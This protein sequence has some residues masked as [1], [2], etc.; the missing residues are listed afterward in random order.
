MSVSNTVDDLIENQSEI[1]ESQQLINSSDELDPTNDNESL[2]MESNEQVP[3]LNESVEI[4]Y[5][6]S[7][8]NN[9]DVLS[10]PFAENTNS[11]DILT[12]NTNSNDILTE[13]T[14]SNHYSIESTNPN[15]SIIENS[16]M[17]NVILTPEGT[18]NQTEPAKDTITDETQINNKA[19]NVCKGDSN[20]HNERNKPMNIFQ[21]KV[22][23]PIALPTILPIVSLDYQSQQKNKESPNNVISDSQLDD[24]MKK[25]IQKIDDSKEAIESN[26]SKLETSLTSSNIASESSDKTNSK[27]N[28]HAENIPANTLDEEIIKVSSQEV[29]NFTRIIE[30]P[31]EKDNSENL[32]SELI[33]QEAD[34]VIPVIVPSEQKQKRKK[35]KTKNS[36]KEL[37][38]DQ[39]SVPPADIESGSMVDNYKLDITRK[40]RKIKES[41]KELSSNLEETPLAN[42]DNKVTPNPNQPIGL[43]NSTDPPKSFSQIEKE[44]ISV[45]YN[46]QPPSSSKKKKSALKNLTKGTISNMNPQLSNNLQVTTSYTSDSTDNL[47]KYKKILPITSQAV[48]PN[49]YPVAHESFQSR[50][51]P[52]LSHDHPP[53]TSQL[54]PPEIKPLSV[55]FVQQNESSHRLSTD[56]LSGYNQFVQGSRSNV[57]HESSSK[58][59]NPNTIDFYERI[60]AKQVENSNMSSNTSNNNTN[61]FTPLP[62]P[63]A[64]ST[65]MDS[66][67]ELLI[68]RA[69]NYPFRRTPNT[70]QSRTQGVDEEEVQYRGQFD[71]KV[72]PNKVESLVDHRM[73]KPYYLPGNQSA[74][75]PFQVGALSRNK[76][77]NSQHVPQTNHDS[78]QRTRS[79]LESSAQLPPQPDSKTI[80]RFPSIAPF[81]E[82]PAPA[83][84]PERSSANALQQSNVSGTLTSRPP[85]RHNQP[86]PADTYKVG[87]SNMLNDTNRYDHMNINQSFRQSK[88]SKSDKLAISAM[89]EL[90]APILPPAM[91]GPSAG[92]LP[93]S[94]SSGGNMQD[95][96]LPA[97]LTSSKESKKAIRSSTKKSARSAM[98]PGINEG[99]E[100]KI[101]RKEGSIINAQTS[102]NIPGKR[103]PLSEFNAL[104][105]QMSYNRNR[106]A[107]E[108]FNKGNSINSRENTLPALSHKPTQLHNQFFLQSSH[109]NQIPP[110]PRNENISLSNQYTSRPAD[111]GYSQFAGLRQ[112]YLPKLDLDRFT[113]D[114]SSPREGIV[115]QRLTKDFS[116]AGRYEQTPL[117]QVAIHNPRHEIGSKDTHTPK[118]I[119]QNQFVQSSIQSDPNASGPKGVSNQSRNI[120]I[121][122]EPYSG[123]FV[124][125]QHSGR[126]DIT[127]GSSH[128]SQMVY[129]NKKHSS[130]LGSQKEARE[131]GYTVLQSG[132]KDSFRPYEHPQ[133]LRKIENRFEYSHNN[134]YVKGRDQSQ[135]MQQSGETRQSN[136]NY[137]HESPYINPTAKYPVSATQDANN[138]QLSQLNKYHEIQSRF[139]SQNQKQGIPSQLQESNNSQYTQRYQMSDHFQSVNHQRN[140]DVNATHQT[141][142]IDKAKLQSHNYERIHTSYPSIQNE[143]DGNLRSSQRYY[144]Q[145]IQSNHNIN[146]QHISLAPI[147]N[148]SLNQPISMYDSILG[149]GQ[150]RRRTGANQGI[151]PNLN[152]L[153][154]G[155]PNQEDSNRKPNASSRSNIKD[156]LN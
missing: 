99:M 26:Q 24:V 82:L 86:P 56:P 102:K 131:K 25:D 84:G 55:P 85:I 64:T 46:F 77:E 11:N 28:I 137:R 144:D 74:V 118:V 133:D 35:Y 73:A 66:E 16:N 128:I 29:Q 40:S 149:A 80:P 2:A 51:Q 155:S 32:K 54:P 147:Q 14:N 71:P 100:T 120:R 20:N 125:S 134:Q 148:Q 114:K 116:Q 151:N 58:P 109:S 15:K 95:F 115:A 154:G 48:H 60:R 135:P 10:H 41:D 152:I 12:E 96:T 9:N 110:N 49:T 13:N 107:N 145:S 50:S 19:P 1:E 61:Y 42:S 90:N 7:P 122:N 39:T 130:I 27:E 69:T 21:R 127:L 91:V 18:T 38:S 98:T 34:Q 129:A 103:D 111:Q 36:K 113:A 123:K 156:L 117:R 8:K 75:Q 106:N 72:N 43:S 83:S 52:T 70:M 141:Q 76:Q 53:Q 67:R 108:G 119:S 92:T 6:Q 33:Q 104:Q 87:G 142:H 138:P 136:A 5:N 44:R 112:D 45:F 93:S 63:L 78:K 101:P 140:Q 143:S 124:E 30:E 121:L 105:N 4:T 97:S 3:V 47:N 132:S 94:K 23:Q 68:N 126:S 22:S 37:T 65:T 153:Q 88:P 31:V 59:S 150:V 17:N 146:S 81:F 57:Q 62:P 89:M 79:I 139:D